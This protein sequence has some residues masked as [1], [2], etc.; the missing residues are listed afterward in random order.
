MGIPGVACG[1]CWV[2]WGN[3]PRRSHEFQSVGDRLQQGE[4]AGG[5]SAGAQ[6]APECA[7]PRGSR[8][9]RGPDD[10][11]QG[12]GRNESRRRGRNHTKRIIKICVRPWP[13]RLACPFHPADHT[14][15]G[16]PTRV[17]PLD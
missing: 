4:W 2:S 7:S 9:S 17:R 15:K 8:V 16:G 6:K 14:K 13:F 3:C 12:A 5:R 11:W 10:G 1:G